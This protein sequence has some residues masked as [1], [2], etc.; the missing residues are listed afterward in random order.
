[1]DEITRM[2]NKSGI[3]VVGIIHSNKRSDVDAVHKVSGAGALAAAVRAVWGFSRD[4]EDK[5]KYHM[6]HVKGN[7]C[8]DKRGLDYSIEECMVPIKGK[9][10]GT[11]RIVW[12]EQ[13]EEDAD[14]RLNAERNSKDVKDT[15]S[16]VAIALIRS[17]IPAKAKDIYRKGEAEGI[18]ASTMKRARYKMGDVVVDKFDNEWWWFTAD[19]SPEKAIQSFKEK[20]ASLVQSAT[21]ALEEEN[22]RA[23]VQ[24]TELTVQNGTVLTV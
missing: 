4:T 3:T 23:T 2:C 7:L 10:A 1:M 14:D 15:K 24:T 5:K 17:A 20:E 16:L 22:S 18:D 6:A 9:N 13:T 8:K 21:I 19:N 12:G 11:P